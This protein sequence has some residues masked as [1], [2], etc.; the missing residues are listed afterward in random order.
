[1]QNK[2]ILVAVVS[3]VVFLVVLLLLHQPYG[4]SALCGIFTYLV[5]SSL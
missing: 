2:P 1:M 3:I 5:A 4:D